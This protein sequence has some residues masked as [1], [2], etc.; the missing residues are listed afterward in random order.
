LKP[1]LEQVEAL[2]ERVKGSVQ[3]HDVRQRHEVWPHMRLWLH[4]PKLWHQGGEVEPLWEVGAAAKLD[5][6]A[7]AEDYHPE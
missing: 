1:L 4:F 5:K 3:C 6:V 2:G 7:A